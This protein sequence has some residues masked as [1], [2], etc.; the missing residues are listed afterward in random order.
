MKTTTLFT[1]GVFILLS[2]SIMKTEKG[3]AQSLYDT[4]WTLKKTHDSTGVTEVYTKAFIKFNEAKKSA[5][6]NGSCNNFGS[7]IE[8]KGHTIHFSDIFSTKMYCE[9][10]QD[11]EDI[12]FRQ[13]AKV[14]RFAISGKTLRLY[15][16]EELLLEFAAE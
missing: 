5:G 2:G 6:G 14:N 1:A 7:S 9:G 4:K 13:L 8:L 15:Q 3:P 10:V 16:G 12:F 11:I